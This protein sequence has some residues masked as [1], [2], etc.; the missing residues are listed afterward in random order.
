MFHPRGFALAMQFDDNGVSTGWSILG[1]GSEPWRYE[2]DDEENACFRQA[3]ASFQ[4]L[5]RLRGTLA[6]DDQAGDPPGH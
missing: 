1:D 3:E 2:M 6:K 5:R 4:A